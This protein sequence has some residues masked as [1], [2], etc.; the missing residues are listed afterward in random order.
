VRD[1]FAFTFDDV[2]IEGYDSHPHI[3]APIA[4]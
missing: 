1:I 4:V 3:A 2:R